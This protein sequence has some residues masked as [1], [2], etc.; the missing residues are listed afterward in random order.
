MKKIISTLVACSLLLFCSACEN[1]G[2]DTG[3][4]AGTEPMQTE[5]QPE[6]RYAGK[7]AAEIVSALTLD[8][9][10]A[11]MVQPA[12]YQL[13]PGMMQVHDYGS[14]LSTDGLMTSSQWAMTV[15]GFQDEALAS[16]AGIPFL[17]GQ[18]DV[19]GVNY[20]LNAV[21]FPHNIGLGAANDPDL[22]YRAGQITAEE[23]KLCHMLWNFAP[24]VAQS[25][26]PRWG[27]TYESYG[28]DLEVIK[29]LATAYTK[30][31]IDGGVVACAKHFLADGNVVFGTGENSDAE[32]LI[33]RG[34]AVLDD[35]QIEELLAVY[36]AEIDAGVQT[37]MVSHSSLNGLKMHENAAYIQRLKQEMGF[38]GFVVSDW[39]AVQNT[40]PATYAEQ[41]ITA[42]NAGIDMLMEVETFE[43][44]RQIIV[45]AV[46]NGDISQERVD[47]AV[48]RIIRVKQDA[49]IFDD[50]YC[51][52]MPMECTQTGSAEYRAVAEQL[53]EE[54][55]VLLKNE[56]GTLPLKAGTAVYITGPAADNAQA[57]CGGWTLA[58]E[59][60]RE[61]NIPGVT[62]IEDGFAEK[63]EEYGITVITDKQKAAEAD[64]VLLVV[65]EKPY[66]EWLGDTE[67]MA[68]CGALGLSGNAKA[69]EAAAELGKPVVTCIV[70]GRQIILDEQDYDSWDSV[71]MCYLPGSEG[72]GVADVL[73]GGAAFQG[74]LPS[75]W[76]ASV[77]Q[78]G[79]G[80]CW[81]E[82]GYGLTYSPET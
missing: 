18:D 70:A 38:T 52:A 14:I 59:G 35:A 78:I 9:K 74:K 64:V 40:S 44:A 72:Q 63:A 23:A 75:P 51:E 15:N 7:T 5:T 46:E 34:D 49:G 41:V 81:L 22:M 45:D 28:S 25:A 13:T 71:V 29:N 79:T 77:A 58:W 67:D 39:N 16:D 50:P 30:G 36:Q 8:Q 55:L 47:D 37:I 69:I 26:D 48:E 62:T 65:G 54:S 82:R 53:V 43:E 17:Y 61:R 11:Q 3:T 21:I 10:A 2:T 80:E 60:S 42:V 56:N 1:S 6:E 32:R 33:D 19:H 24:C 27:R 31:L 20:C 4:N 76:Y 66:A 57:Q 12:I 68:L 73:C